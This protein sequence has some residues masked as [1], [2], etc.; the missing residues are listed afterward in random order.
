MLAAP[1]TSTLTAGGGA[2]AGDTRCT[3]RARSSCTPWQDKRF[4]PLER[5]R[6]L[7]PLDRARRVD[8]LRAHLRALPHERASP[9]PVV[10]RQH[11]EP[12]VAPFVTRVEIVALRE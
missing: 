2:T 9:D 10:L 3:P 12:L 1:A 5:R 4:E 7:V 11:L 6:E 8:M